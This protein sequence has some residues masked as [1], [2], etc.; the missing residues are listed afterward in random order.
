M[1]KIVICSGGF[2]PLHRGHVYYMSQARLLGDYLIVG[3]NSD[4]WLE[5]KKGAFFLPFNDR[6]TI[7]SSLRQVS[8]ATGFDDSDDSARDLIRRYAINHP[9]AEIIFANGGDRTKDNIPEM[10]LQEEIGPR[11]KF[12]F[13]VGGDTKTNSSS[14]ILDR[15][16]LRERRRIIAMIEAGGY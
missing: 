13:G 8:L 1:T 15:W 3:V 9:D 10:D 11:L 5:R 4:D 16:S 12:V 6:V 7:V 14:A 2:D